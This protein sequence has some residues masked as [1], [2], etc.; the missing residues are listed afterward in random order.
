LFAAFH[1]YID[2]Q[3]FKLETVVAKVVTQS[4]SPE[5]QISFKTKKMFTAD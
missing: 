4:A 5:E 3:V 2:I 1:W